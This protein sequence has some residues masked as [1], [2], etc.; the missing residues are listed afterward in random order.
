MS[1][2]REN[3]AKAVAAT[4]AMEP[5][6]LSFGSVPSGRGQVLQ[7]SVTLTN[8]TGTAQTLSRSV[9]VGMGAGVTFTLPSGALTLAPGANQTV[10]AGMAAARGTS[11]GH[12]Q[13]VLQV[14]AGGQPAANAML[15]FLVKW[16]H[17]TAR[18]RSRP[19]HARL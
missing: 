14:S 16:P 19:V 13:A 1:T 5:V 17:R 2:G 15:R 3:L 12:K 4:V 18:R 6:S 8:L 10:A 7:G 9:A 11:A